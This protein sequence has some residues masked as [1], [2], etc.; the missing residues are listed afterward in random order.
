MGKTIKS[1]G[2]AVG[3]GSTKVP[4]VGNI[5]IDKTPFQIEK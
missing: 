2:S 1:I 3:L 5:S 4:G